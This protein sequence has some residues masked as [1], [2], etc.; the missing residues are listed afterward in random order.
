M[1]ESRAIGVCHECGEIMRDE[2]IM[3][4]WGWDV[5]W[6]CDCFPTTAEIN[7]AKKELRELNN[8]NKQVNDE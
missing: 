7:K 3:T 1:S 8:R 2:V 4:P 6:A 5:V